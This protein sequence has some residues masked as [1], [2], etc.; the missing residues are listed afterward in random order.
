MS[1]PRGEIDE[2]PSVAVHQIHPHTSLTLHLDHHDPHF[3]ATYVNDHD[4]SQTK[5]IYIPHSTNSREREHSLKTSYELPKS[6]IP[7]RPLTIS[8]LPFRSLPI[9][10]PIVDLGT[11]CTTYR[12]STDTTRASPSHTRPSLS[13]ICNLK[14]ERRLH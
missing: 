9:L 14:L 5:Y 13:Y 4:D 2:L 8:T 7:S 12:A 11:T 6:G 3:V 10:S 1:V